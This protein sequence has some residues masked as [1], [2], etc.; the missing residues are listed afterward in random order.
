MRKIICIFI[1]IFLLSFLSFAQADEPKKESE[2]TLKIAGTVIDNESAEKYLK[3][4]DIFILRYPKAQA[5]LPV[6]VESGY[7]I[8]S[9][10][11]LYRFNKESSVKITEFLEE[12]N[13]VLK[14]VIEAKEVDDEL[15]LLSIKNEYSGVRG[16]KNE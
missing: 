6:S 4:L 9:E 8:Y 10:G 2:E 13:N 15:E 7:S 5:V 14:V 12:R 1:S 16:G 11:E 3:S